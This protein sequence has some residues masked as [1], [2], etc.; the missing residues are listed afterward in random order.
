MTH[1]NNACLHK[2]IRAASC[3]GV[4]RWLSFNAPKEVFGHLEP[5]FSFGSSGQKLL[6]LLL[7]RATAGGKPLR[8]SRFC[9]RTAKQTLFSVSIC[10]QHALLSCLTC[11][12]VSIHLARTQK[13]TRDQES[14]GQQCWPHVIYCYH[15]PSQ[16]CPQR[17]SACSGAGFRPF[18][19]RSW[20]RAMFWRALWHKKQSE[21]ARDCEMRQADS[22]FWH[23]FAICVY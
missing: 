15:L 11:M 1:A 23:V 12:P 18:T 16:A 2:A 3:S 17:L 19:W 9:V 14:C 22:T 5:G 10:A 4:S 20:M 6:R 13:K 21:R 7:N 8:C